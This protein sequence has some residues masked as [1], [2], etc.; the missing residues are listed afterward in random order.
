[1]RRNVALNAYNKT[2]Y[3]D[4]AKAIMLQKRVAK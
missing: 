1:M 3:V 2:T 4:Q